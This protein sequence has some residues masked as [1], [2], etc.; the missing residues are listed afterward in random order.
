M[1]AAIISAAPDHSSLEH[2]IQ[3]HTHGPQIVRVLPA[4]RVGD[5]DLACCFKPGESITISM[6]VAFSYSERLLSHVA[7][8][9]GQGVL[10]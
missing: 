7:V 2:V 5:Y 1:S 8:L 9:T 6:E 10:L 3:L 4:R